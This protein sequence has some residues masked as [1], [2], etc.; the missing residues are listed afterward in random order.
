MLV[1]YWMAS[2]AITARADMD[3]EATLDLMRQ[4]K[5][6][7]LPII[8]DGN[9]LCGILALSDVYPFIGPHE[10][11][12]AEL[13]DEQ[14][15]RLR[16][17]R[18]DAVMTPSPIT[19]DR[20]APLEE[21]GA[22]MRRHRI[23]AVPVTEGDRLVGIIT[24]SDILGALANIARMGTDG[25]RICFRIPVEEKFDIFYT[26]VSLCQTNHMEILTLLTHPLSTNSHLV[27]LRVRGENIESFVDALWRSH[28]EVLAS[29]EAPQG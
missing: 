7:R 4:N 28:Y 27:M 12:R 23:G 11:N 13:T 14:R 9:Q 16:G 15:Q 5:I 21:V 1:R 25:R 24:E 20:N 8:A 17:L 26:L 19:C 6:R 10:L 2:P 22:L 18:V 29:P 3:L